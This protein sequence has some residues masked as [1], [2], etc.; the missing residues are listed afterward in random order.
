MAGKPPKIKPAPNKIPDIN[1]DGFHRP[2]GGNLPSSS[3]L[4][5]A[6]P[7]QPSSRPHTAESVEVISVIPNLM[8]PAIPISHPGGVVAISVLSNYWI[9]V[10][11]NMGEANEQG[12]R[13]LKQRQ[14]VAV[15]EE[16]Y[17]QVVKDADSGLFRA[18]VTREREPSGPLLKP[19][20]EGK[21][22]YPV[23]SSN[24]AHEHMADLFHRMGYAIDEF[25][26]ITLAHIL[27]VSGV[28]GTLARH[29]DADVHPPALLQDTLR[30]FSL[31]QKMARWP[32]ED[33]AAVFKAHE[34]AFE[35]DCDENTLQMRRIFPDLPKTVA[36]AIWR[37]TTAAERLHM[38]NQS[39][40]PP[41]VATETL[42][43]LREAR[44]ARAGEGLYLNAVSNLDSDRL[45]LYMIGNL[46][47]WPQ[48]IRIEMRQ[49]VLD[50]EV[51]SAIGD[52][53]S[54][55]RHVLIRQDAGYLVQRADGQSTQALHDLYSAVC[56]LLLPAQ[57][58]VLGMPEAAGPTLQRWVRAQPLPPRQTVSEVL[59]LEPLPL[60][61]EAVTA[62]YRQAGYLRGG[63]DENPE[64]GRF[65][66][67]RVRD[68]YPELSDED[69]ARFINE[70]LHSDPSGVLIRLEKEF[71]TLR[72]E[73][74]AWSAMVPP[75]HTEGEVW[76]PAALANQ[77]QL[78]QGFSKD[79]QA[80]WQ[81]KLITPHDAQGES[82]SSFIDFAG[83][84][85][86]TSA[87]F[88]HVTELVLEARNPSVKLGKLLDSFPNLRYLILQRVRMETFAPG[89]FQMRDLRHLV[90]QDCSLQLSDFD[91]E[92]LSRIE[93]LTLLR[94]DE[95]PLGVA[96]HVG[97]M[98]QLGEL[99]LSDAGLTQ[100][101]S[102]VEQLASLRVL[103]VH[104]NNIVNIREE[105]FELPDTQNLDINLIDNPLGD[106]ALMRIGQYVQGASMDRQVVIRVREPVANDVVEVFDSPDTGIESSSD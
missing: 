51:L 101:P 44:L 72:Q 106:V 85:P 58:K 10:S 92:G 29:T 23:E 95:N 6:D 3:V 69:V 24:S 35:V 9:P 32:K 89:I 97:F 76:S 47:D 20:S 50:G 14:Y 38:H 1:T 73:L 54:P 83:E 16:H 80:L 22:W 25:S 74:S 65:V 21:L 43:A 77:L 27:A 75:H 8:P 100:I 104:D 71:A 42:V 78:R 49:G 4:R 11:R 102:G 82:F 19:D 7:L 40:L 93:T 34:R 70:H 64:P 55:V 84:L 2:L 36:E 91:A 57:R 81:K 52:G 53:R 39:G 41:R 67:K 48:Q 26:D 90:L 94:L 86:H 15:D 87:R 66:E 105:F 59:G 60:A 99:Y 17:V 62:Q 46:A 98:H 103:D 63:A 13:V 12:I 5:Q 79:L 45:A 18:T 30:R 61:I 96:P 31:D 28:D 68:L 37:N 56:L 88:E 33:R